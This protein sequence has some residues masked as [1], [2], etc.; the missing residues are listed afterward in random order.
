MKSFR[1]VS[2]IKYRQVL[3]TAEKVI[4]INNQDEKNTVLNDLY[5]LIH[6]FVGKCDNHHEDWRE[7]GEKLEVNLK[8]F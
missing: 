3:E 5:K 8:D 1:K 2:P 4:T 6:P 7:Y